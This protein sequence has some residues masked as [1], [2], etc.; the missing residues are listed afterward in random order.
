MLGL[1][2]RVGSVVAAEPVRSRRSGGASPAG[3]LLRLCEP[4]RIRS[5]YDEGTNRRDPAL[6]TSA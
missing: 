4:N 1:A 2:R 3:E 6:T 5:C